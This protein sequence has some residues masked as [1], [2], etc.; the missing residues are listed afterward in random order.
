MACTATIFEIPILLDVICDNLSPKDIWN[1]YRCNKSWRSLFDPY[2]SRIVQYA[3][4]NSSQS[5]SIIHNS[6]QIRN[7][8]VDLADAGY[9]LSS[10]CINLRKLVCVDFGYTDDTSSIDPT[11]NALELIN[12]NPKLQTLEIIHRADSQAPQPFHDSILKALSIHASLR[13]IVINI[14]LPWEVTRAFLSHLPPKLEELTM[15]TYYYVSQHSDP[16]NRLLPLQLDRPTALRRITML[17]EMCSPQ[18]YFLPSLLLYCPDLEEI[19]VPHYSEG[20][21]DIAAI[22]RANCPKLRVLNQ[23]VYISPFFECEMRQL[24]STAFPNGVRRLVL[25]KMIKH[26]RDRQSRFLSILAKSPSAN[27][28]EVL[29]MERPRVYVSGDL[30]CILQSCPKLRVLRLTGTQQ[31]RNGTDISDIVS[32]LSMPWRCQDT[33]EVLELDLSNRKEDQLYKQ[34]KNR[35]AIQERTAHL[36]R[37]LHDKLRSIKNLKSLTLNWK[38]QSFQGEA[39]PLEIGL[40]YLNDDWGQSIPT[41]MKKMTRADLRWMGLDWNTLDDIRQGKESRK[42][43]HVAAKE[44]TARLEYNV[45]IEDEVRSI[46]QSIDSEYE[47]PLQVNQKRLGKSSQVFSGKSL[48]NNSAWFQ[49]RPR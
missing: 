36:V 35:S 13:S 1:C 12:K 22:L 18:H 27:T 40:A 37:Q 5:S 45:S 4:L 29:E 24:L 26:S 7:L 2:R 34:S 20:S 48:K 39:I 47:W 44:R 21:R 8:K 49:K 41:L 19:S 33:L 6:H 30:V 17:D 25:G 43:E 15:M 46:F 28:I 11:E 3:Y 38:S 31:S 10:T 9:F 16:A 42:M 14:R 23:G 32:S